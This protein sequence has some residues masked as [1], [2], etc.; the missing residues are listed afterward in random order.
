[1]QTAAESLNFNPHS[2]G[3]L[4][5]GTYDSGSFTPIVAIDTER[6]AENF[7]DRILAV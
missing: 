7:G 2:H 1:V 6:M 4:A 5:T 3:L